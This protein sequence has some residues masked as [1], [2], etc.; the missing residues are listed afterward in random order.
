MKCASVPSA[1]RNCI[2]RASV[3]T[4]R[5]FSPARNVRSITLPSEARRSFVRTNAPPLPGLTCWNSRTLKIVPSTS[6]WL[7]F[8]NWLVEIMCGRKGSPH[9]ALTCRSS[10]DGPWF[11]SLVASRLPRLLPVDP[12]DRAWAL[13]GAIATIGTHPVA[14]LRGRLWHSRF[15]ATQLR[16][17][18]IR[19]NLRPGQSFLDVGAMWRVDGA[20]SFFAERLGAGAVTALDVMAPT[21]GFVAAHR[22]QD[23]RVVYVNGDIN[24][25]DTVTELQPHDVVWCA[26]VLYHSPD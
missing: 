18:A 10:T 19:S 9:A 7:P 22:S 5:N 14:W 2:L 20:C 4:A 8:L 26:G 17:E 3:R 16:E 1:Y 13:R 12:H 24:E 15:N 25:P 11:E 6:M 21:P 23:S